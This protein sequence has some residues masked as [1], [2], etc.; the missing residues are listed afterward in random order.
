[1]PF[2]DY[3]AA[4][5]AI[6]GIKALPVSARKI[7]TGAFNG[8]KGEGYDDAAAAATAWAQVKKSGYYKKGDK[9]T[10]MD[11]LGALI[12]SIS[13]EVDGDNIAIGV[14]FT[15]VD[16]VNRTV[17]G[18]A[19]LDNLDKSNEIVDFEASRDAFKSWI[20]N[21]R[22][23]HAPKAVGKAVD[24]QE[25]T[26]EKDGKTYK[27]IFVRSKI[28]KGAEDTWQKVL[29]GTLSGY[30]IG[31]RVLERRPE[32]IKGEGTYYA[33]QHGVRIT[34]YHLG[35]L[36]VVDNPM[37]PLAL[38]SDITK[39]DFLVKNNHGQ[40]E[41]TSLL[42]EKRGLFYCDD[43]DAAKMDVSTATTVECPTCDNMISK[44]ADVDEAPGITELK[45]MVDDYHD[46]QKNTTFADYSAAQSTGHLNIP[47]DHLPRHQV[48]DVHE[49]NNDLTTD[50]LP[51]YVNPN[52]G[53]ELQETPVA[54]AG[55]RQAGEPET[56]TVPFKV[57][58]KTNEGGV[59]VDDTELTSRPNNASK[60]DPTAELTHNA[61]DR[62]GVTYDDDAA[63]KM[64]DKVLE[65]LKGRV[66]SNE[67]TIKKREED[68]EFIMALLDFDMYRAT[69]SGSM[70]ANM[71]ESMA[72]QTPGGK[73]KK[74]QTS[75]NVQNDTGDST[76][77]TAKA[78]GVTNSHASAPKGKPSDRGQYAD[79]ENFKYPID[80]AG[81][82]R[83][84]VA[85]FNHSG[86]RGAGGYSMSKW[87]SIG[88]K[89]AGAASRT[90]GGGYRYSGG[91]I[92]VPSENDDAKKAELA[93]ELQKNT[94]NGT[95]VNDYGSLLQN[96]IKL[97]SQ[98][99]NITPN[100]APYSGGANVAPY[101]GGAA[102]KGGE[103]NTVEKAELTEIA[104]KLND[105]FSVAMKEISDT[106]KAWG[107]EAL[108]NEDG[109]GETHG[110]ATVDEGVG[111]S[112]DS[113]SVSSTDVTVA[114]ELGGLG[115]ANNGP[116]K[117]VPHADLTSN[118]AQAGATTS[119]PAGGLSQDA[120]PE[121]VLPHADLTSDASGSADVSSAQGLAAIGKADEVVDLIKNMFTKLESDLEEKIEEVVGKA[122]GGKKS[123]EVGT[124]LSK[125]DKGSS[126]WGGAFYNGEL[127]K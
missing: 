31:G 42:I 65:V 19:T 24:I 105:I 76:V 126:V 12:K 57:G 50:P 109:S 58:D 78:D 67:N 55:A 23:M 81:R 26:L 29:D 125:S 80:N 17:E 52:P 112:P 114:K 40:L 113:G 90:F 72:G 27:G 10:K 1:M 6:P 21:V 59:G 48:N 75:S 38:F 37:N 119:N 93:V 88:R 95:N 36:S 34:K 84:A 15:R 9:W 70:N 73:K 5:A 117:I 86:Q 124:E 28:S 123:L 4:Q 64:A 121:K 82:V 46:L 13:V 44:I 39:G 60:E 71:D 68:E 118:A 14:P 22:E 62:N 18:F 25:K 122:G 69:A 92:S 53:P 100:V 106:F 11:D 54:T 127:S 85:Y 120:G 96:I 30:S 47:D 111:V 49:M 61:N 2:K 74:K 56:P 108:N 107:V 16:A 79:P 8:A 116:E 97:L 99:T 110:G 3:L 91:K 98:K 87:A 63:E 104:Q 45:K 43:C 115:E 41:P 94:T 103:T 32:V 51:E 89:I 77:T 7:F 66:E 102:V 20:G 83:A 35:E 33:T 101:N